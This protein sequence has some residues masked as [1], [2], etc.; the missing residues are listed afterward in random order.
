MARAKRVCAQPGCP[1]LVISGKCPVH[2][3]MADKRR[4]SRQDRGYD[5]DY[6]RER[7]RWA[8][9]V[10]AGQTHCHAIVCVMPARWICPGTPWDLGHDD[11]R[12]IRGP[13][14]MR[15]NRSAGGKAAHE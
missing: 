15:C 9:K 13:E 8:P 4:G 2:R 5:A 7:R 10:E 11:Q 1:T 12:R 3:R 14:H 6:D